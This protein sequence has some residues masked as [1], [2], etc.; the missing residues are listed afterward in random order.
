MQVSVKTTFTEAKGA[1]D[2][3]FKRIQRQ[4]TVTGLFREIRALATYMQRLEAISPIRAVWHY[5]METVEAMDVSRHPRL[6]RM[7]R[8]V[9]AEILSAAD[10]AQPSYYTANP[11]GVPFRR[12]VDAATPI[13]N[14][15][16]EN[17]MRVSRK[18]SQLAV[19]KRKRIFRG[20]R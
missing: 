2:A 17:A 5:D 10:A 6:Q 13:L 1:V 20:R 15:F 8:Q 12:R 11:V 9:I 7:K 18:N 16:M 19:A 14:S 4:T 3:S